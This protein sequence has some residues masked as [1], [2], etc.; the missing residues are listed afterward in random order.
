M[1]TKRFKPKNDRLIVIIWIVS[2]TVL[3]AMTIVTLLAAYTP[4]ALAVMLATDLLVLYFLVSP[5]F[6]YV[7]LREKTLFV[8]FGFILRREIEYRTVRG[9][10][11][12]RKWYSDSMLS[13]KNSL[14][15]VN[16]K[17]GRFDMMSVSVTD[18]DEFIRE[19]EERVRAAKVRA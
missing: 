10:S 11:V 8:R 9:T 18:N 2:C 5:L 13:L 14:D 7:E 15:H 3:A 6:G 1:E 19:L 4:F 12:A 17:Y 16:V